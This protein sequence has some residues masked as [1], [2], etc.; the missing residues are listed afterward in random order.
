LEADDG[1]KTFEVSQAEIK[2][3]VDLQTQSKVSSFSFDIY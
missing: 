2:D 3:A 1:E